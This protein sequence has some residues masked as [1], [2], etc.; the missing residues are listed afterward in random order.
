MQIFSIICTREPNLNSITKA[1][2]AKLSSFGIVVK[3]L[4]NQSSIFEAYKKGLD[5]CNADN[6][7]IIIFCHDDLQILS[8]K[9][10]FIS[11]LAPCVIQ[12]T[13][14]VGPAGT[15]LLGQD[16]IWWKQDRWAAGYHRG[17]VKHISKGQISQRHNNSQLMITPTS[18]GPHGRVVA[19]DGLFLAARKEVWDIIGLDKPTYFEGLWDFYDIHYTTSA[20]LAGYKN[21]TV[22]IDLIHHSNGELVGRDSWHKNREAFIAN[23]KLP[24]KL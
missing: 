19:L 12:S 9:I 21:Y 16:A 7:D 13:G 20:H 1:L 15:T 17:I 22:D 6:N 14:I 18:Y 24:M 3:L 5:L 23:T 2:V 4:I 8:D 10:P 11:A